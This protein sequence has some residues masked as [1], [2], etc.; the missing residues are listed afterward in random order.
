[1]G[2][3][4]AVV[5]P[6]GSGKTTYCWGLQQ[7]FKA[8][9]R[10]I[11]LINLD[12]AVDN[13][14]YEAA[15]DIRELIRL[16]E[17]MEFHKLGP[18]G[19]ILFCLEFLEKNFDWFSE[20]LAAL[21][22]PSSSSTSTSTASAA[23]GSLA[24]EIDYIV[25]DLPGQ[26]EISTDHDSL[27]N[28]LHKLEKLDWRLAVVQLTDSTH[29]VDPVKYISIVLL[30]LKTMLHLGLPQV[31]VLTKIDLLK[32]FN[33]D[34]KLKLEFYTD[35]QDLSY[36][37]PLLENQISD[38]FANLNKAI[39]ELIE[40]FNLVGFESLCVED[41][42]SMTRLILTID[43]A[44]GY[45]PSHQPNLTYPHEM[46][47]DNN[48]QKPGLTTSGVPGGEMAIEAEFGSSSGLLNEI[49]ER[50]IDYPELYDQF[51][52]QLWADESELVLQRASQL[53]QINAIQQNQK[54]P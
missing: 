25:L 18:N 48:P 22:S 41:K 7:Y 19:S 10:P 17:V 16:E 42:T 26:V 11:V 47:S 14:P 12:P 28:I 6:P 21:T 35:V 2:F 52:K 5:G 45:Y 32:H 40:D 46:G 30:N 20:R 51:Q 33:E 27:K 23:N 1:M 44:L 36:L 9:S 31:N 39:I 29:I 24:Q 53:N 43:K 37:L 15:I 13:L 38:K 50:W 54:Q 34:F 3:G 8:I 4:Q 49:Q